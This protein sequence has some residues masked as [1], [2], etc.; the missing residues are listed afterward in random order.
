MRLGSATITGIV[1][2]KR[3]VAEGKLPHPRTR[4]STNLG[5]GAPHRLLAWIMLTAMGSCRLVYMGVLQG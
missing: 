2:L 5:G 1:T 3:D 4:S